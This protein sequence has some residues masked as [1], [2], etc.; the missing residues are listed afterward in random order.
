[1][2]TVQ[3][4]SSGIVAARFQDRAAAKHWLDCNNYAEDT[5]IIDP[6]SGEVTGWSKGDCLNLFKIVK[7]SNSGMEIK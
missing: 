2:Y 6:D 1:M 4:R 3:F 5:P 7:A